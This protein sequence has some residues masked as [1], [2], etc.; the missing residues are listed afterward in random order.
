M[1]T[2]MGPVTSK[3]SRPGAAMLVVLV[4]VMTATLISLG[5]I[6]K[7]DVELV[8][9]RNVGLRMRMDYLAQSGLVHAKALITNPQERQFR[10]G[11]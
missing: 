4:I 11:R 2:K 8:C 9:G 1:M 3:N 10:P 6:A 5:F 7:S